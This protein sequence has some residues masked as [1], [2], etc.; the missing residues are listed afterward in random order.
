MI[1]WV[2]GMYR[3]LA[4]DIRCYREL[5]PDKSNEYRI[6]MQDLSH[7]FAKTIVPN[8]EFSD[9]SVVQLKDILY[10]APREFVRFFHYYY[11]VRYG[12]NKKMKEL[13]CKSK[14]EYYGM[15]D[16]LHAYT[17]GRLEGVDFY[18]MSG[19][20]SAPSSRPVL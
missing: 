13:G 8:I 19:P 14:Q 9:A 16:R 17:Q 3:D 12:R 20:T 15:R 5:Y 18:D 2:D 6:M 11:V 10:T 4:H 7:G 1:D